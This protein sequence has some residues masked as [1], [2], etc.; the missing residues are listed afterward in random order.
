MHAAKAA[1]SKSV[2][3]LEDVRL[4]VECVGDGEV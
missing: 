1:Q 3:L 4:G 2:E